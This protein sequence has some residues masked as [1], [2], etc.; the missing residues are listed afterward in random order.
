MRGKLVIIVIESQSLG[1]SGQDRQ[2]DIVIVNQDK[3]KRDITHIKNDDLTLREKNIRINNLQNYLARKE[4]QLF[5]SLRENVRLKKRTKNQRYQLEEFS[6]RGSMKSICYQPSKA[7]DENKFKDLTVLKSMLE[8]CANFHRK[9]NGKRYHQS[10]KE[11]Y[12][13]VMY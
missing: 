12:E 11:L 8:T 6:K 1:P 10:V 13:V 2:G 4:S 5:F 7:A 9:K 3:K